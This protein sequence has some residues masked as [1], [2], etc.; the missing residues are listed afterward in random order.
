MKKDVARGTP[1]LSRNRA[2]A[3]AQAV[4]H[5][6]A[7]RLPEAERHY[8][9]IL[10]VQPQHPDANHNMGLL[11]IQA[12]R[13]KDAL[14]YFETA[15][16]ALPTQAQFW[17]GYAE[18][19]IRACQPEV[20]MQ[21]LAQGRQNGLGGP[22][23]EALSAWA[24]V[25]TRGG[26]PIA[27]AVVHHWAGRLNEAV[28]SYRRGL[29]GKPDL[30]EAHGCLGLALY[31]LG[32]LTEA[33]ESY[34]NA[35][36]ILPEDA[37]SHNNLGNV[38]RGLG[39]LDEAEASCRRAAELKPE[40]VE[41]HYNRGIALQ[42]LGRLEDA[43]ASYRRALA[44]NPDVAP[45]HNNL[46]NALRDLGRL[47]EAVASYGRALKIKP[48]TPGVHSNLANTLRDLGRLAEAEASCLR[49]L[50]IKPDFAEAHQVLG[51]VLYDLGRLEE[52][53]AS[54][55]RALAAKPTLAEAHSSLGM[56]LVILGRL[57]EALR[58]CVSALRLVETPVAKT[59]FV[60]CIKRMHLTACGDDVRAALVRALT[61]PWGRPNHLMPAGTILVKHD[62]D[63]GACIAR[64]ART[65][66]Q[67]L[68]ARDL[69]AA[70]GLGAVSADTLLRAML[71]SAPICDIELERFLTT[72]RHAMLAAA[73]GAE[74]NED[75]DARLLD[76]HCALARQCFI[77]EYVFDLTASEAEQLRMLRDRVA[78][79]L[80]ADAPIPDLWLVT[81]A[82]YAPLHSLPSC[83]RLLD[84]TWPEA[85]SAVLAQQVREP[86]EELGL[87]TTIG[88]L[89]TID[90]DVSRRVRQQYEE[91]P[92]PRWI[93]AAPVDKPLDIDAVLCRTFPSA[94]F[95]PLNKAT[96]LEVLI[97]GCGT[98]QQAIDGAQLYKGA[99][100]LAVDLSLSSL[101]YAKRK[102][103]D[104]GLDTIEYGQADITKL[105]T[106][107]RSFDL[108]EA[109][110]VLHHLADPM[111]GWRVLLGLLRPGGFMRV[112][113][114]S[115]T[116]RRDVVRGREF[117][118][119]RNYGSTKEEIRRCRQDLVENG[120]SEI[121]GWDD[122]FSTSAC[123]DLLFHVQ[124]SRMRLDA[125][126]DFLNDNGLR[127][128][129]FE[130]DKQILNAYG[131]RFPNDRAATN[132]RNW[133]MFEE[134]NSDIFRNMYQ[135]WVQKP[136]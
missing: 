67:R 91:N 54:Y 129:G 14:P 30:A 58:H 76:F 21:V 49:A 128:L 92:Y 110:G 90:D 117:I 121:L 34:R 23:M 9:A 17:T 107:G 111:A 26:K 135:F 50:G 98:G 89:T 127:F 130:T 72:V 85:V 36:R 95:E 116:A 33:A 6:Q 132:L 42:G 136:H 96:E 126:D 78:A 64:T 77:N 134:E 93:R 41:A 48:D 122:F 11:A 56:V 53:E 10:R 113:L 12:G 75:E 120:F 88:R 45:A 109:S 4:A 81:L 101:C 97:A 52:A 118:A 13:P 103:V 87:R 46:G 66:P 83:S 133:Q 123:R 106:L 114:Y 20:A 63:L 57:D 31:D 59:L 73:T 65:W 25:A 70:S 44:V 32:R 68:P 102:T 7:G 74:A 51:N 22:N 105:D 82:S 124:E 94:S 29:E 61:E 3:L 1:G 24:T 119:A 15:L 47:E 40:F 62:Q 125:I 2:N 112:G 100:L 28:T 35:I 84:R 37:G 108:V 69:F 99:R 43:V 79:A 39:R 27:E 115:D 104:L 16:K 86:A 18:A 55:R 60:D 71:V 80:A 131:R 38:L 19:L 5:H 8:R